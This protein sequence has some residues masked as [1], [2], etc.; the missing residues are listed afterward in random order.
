MGVVKTIERSGKRALRRV[1]GAMLRAPRVS[2]AEVAAM[3]FDRVLVIRQ[4]NQMGDMLLA[5]PALRA[6]KA[7]HPGA[8]VHVV[9]STLNRGVMRICPYVDVVHTYDKRNVA[10]H[11][12]LVRRLR[13]QRFDV[14][15]VLH[16]VSFSFT[17][18]VLAVLS[19][20]RLRVG[21]TSRGIGDSLS[22]SWLHLTLPLPDDAELSRMNEAE[23]NLY[24][25]R[26]IGMTTDDLA[27]E[28]A[29]DEASRRWAEQFAAQAWRNGA[30]RLVVHP[31]AGK[32]E[33]IW[34]PQRF[35][36]VVDRIA[37]ARDVAVVAVEGPRDREVVEAFAAA[38]KVPV[39]VARGRSIGDVA[40]LL[41][42]ADLTLCNDTGVMH[43]AAA[44]G[45][46]TLGVFGPT[47]PSRWAPRSPGLSV[48]RAHDG[49]LLSVEAEAVAAKALEIL[50][51]VA[52]AERD[53]QR[54]GLFRFDGDL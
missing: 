14:A 44:A 1:L 40:A 32:R 47:D 49:R 46:R 8:S 4:H 27:P 48:V 3:K 31:G 6:I 41:R 15:I 52:G 17:S 36:D 21:S 45:A 22:G 37:G 35:A 7:A 53:V 24:P 29:P 12:G 5:I 33:T 18:L 42:L 50:G 30:V 11:V 39:T 2:A 10:G 38:C 13:G 19:G 26:A 34:P 25:L 28:I 23:H 43:V 54:Q 51:S 9:S 20:A 16:T